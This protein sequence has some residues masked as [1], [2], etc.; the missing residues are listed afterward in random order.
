MVT[1]IVG[2]Q[3]C[4]GQTAGAR[5][6]D[7]C[8]GELAH[9]LR[10]L[11]A[12]LPDLRSMAA[13]KATVMAKEQGHGS[14]TVAPIPLNAGAWQLQQSIE[15]FSRTLAGVLTLQYGHLPAESLLKAVAQRAPA[16]M[17]RRD[18]A[19]IHTLATI[20]ARRLDRQLE[21]PQSRILIGQCP[22]C[23]DDVWSSEEDLAA[24]W[25][26]CTC[27]QTININQVQE[28]RIFKLAISDAQGT[29]AALSKLLKGCGI[30][31]SVETIRQWK[32]RGIIKPIGKQGKKPVYRL[33]DVWLAIT[34]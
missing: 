4:G 34:R 27:G 6:C 23:G 19:S 32:K 11:A 29:A 25:Q 12:R 5:V 9:T 15:K 10:H 24:G 31:I 3:V 1:T 17:Q 33:W 21:P 30:T 7:K 28:Q 2:C 20:A 8:T 26:P 18:A 22:Y 16:L 14:R 13:K